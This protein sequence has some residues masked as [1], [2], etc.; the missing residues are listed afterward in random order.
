MQRLKRGKEKG[1]R[2]RALEYVERFLISF[3][4]QHWGSFSE[5]AQ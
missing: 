2:S 5:K 4:C 1:D 3:I